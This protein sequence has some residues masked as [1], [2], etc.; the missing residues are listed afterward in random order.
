ML[1]LS[2]YCSLVAAATLF[3]A[4]GGLVAAP[5]PASAQETVLKFG[6]YLNE[7]DVRFGALKH[8]ADLIEKGT[9]GRVKLQLFG[10]STLHPHVKCIDAVQAGVS[11]ICMLAGSSVQ[12]KRLPC[13]AQTHWLPMIIDWEKNVEI[14]VE[15]NAILK[16]EF[17]KA[18]LVVVMSQNFSYDQE[19]F[20][21]ER[22][23]SLE[24]MK[25]R[26]VRTVSPM[27]D[28]IIKKFGGSP[29]Q[30]APTEMY[31]AA[32]RGVVDGMNV[33]A[34]TFLSWKLWPVMPHLLL[35]QGFYGNGMN[36]MSKKKFDSLRPADQKVI[37]EAGVETAKWLKPRYEDWINM[38]IGEGIFKHGGSVYAV[39]KKERRKL[40]ANMAEGWNEKM[41]EAC[42]SER[43]G[44]LRAL[45]EKYGG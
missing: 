8:F 22:T 4:A 36:S 45:F 29:V 27:L 10:S 5:S 31:Q 38:R 37:L 18:G 26:S 14:D 21:T 28:H 13:A 19:W 39:P 23:T 33:G 43:A 34:A 3:A 41:D 32:E 20:F 9:Q 40:V 42:G 11:D 25:G 12:P 17:D 44:K 6:T 1:R 24:Q 30:I 7:A 2:R 15:Y 35:V 16:P